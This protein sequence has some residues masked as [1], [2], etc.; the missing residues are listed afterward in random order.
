MQW[1]A[2]SVIEWY[3]THTHTLQLECMIK[4]YIDDLTAGGVHLGDTLESALELG[5]KH[6]AFVTKCKMV[7]HQYSHIQYSTVCSSE[8]TSNILMPRFL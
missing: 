5:E 1:S 3:H 4:E 2:W 6:E 7:S 8:A